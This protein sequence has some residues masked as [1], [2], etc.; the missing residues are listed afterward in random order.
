MSYR[1]GSRGPEV[2]R[3][4]QSLQQHGQHLSVDGRYGRETGD[5]VRTFQ[6]SHHLRADGVVGPR[7]AAVLGLRGDGFDAAPPRRH[8]SAAS[9]RVPTPAPPPARA[10]RPG[11]AG[12]RP[13]ARRPPT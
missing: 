1:I 11:S 3:M 10:P 5:A 12:L 6:R 13:C 8:G 7:T 4:Q 2:S 9:P